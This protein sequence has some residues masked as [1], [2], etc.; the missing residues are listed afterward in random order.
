MERD[1]SMLEWSV[2]FKERIWSRNACGAIK[3]V[4]ERDPLEG[5]AGRLTLL[6]NDPCSF[7]MVSNPAEL[8]QGEWGRRR[9]RRDKVRKHREVTHKVGRL[10]FGC[11]V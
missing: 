3:N 1:E 6:P 5:K 7:A 2:R 11:K 9:R 8:L 10:L 4:G